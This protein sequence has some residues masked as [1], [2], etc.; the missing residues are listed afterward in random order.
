MDQ[1][2]EIVTTSKIKDNLHENLFY[3]IKRVNILSKLNY[4]FFFTSDHRSCGLMNPPFSASRIDIWVQKLTPEYFLNLAVSMPKDF[5]SLIKP[6]A[7]ISINFVLYRSY[8]TVFY[9]FLHCFT[10]FYIDRIKVD[11]LITSCGHSMCKTLHS[12]FTIIFAYYL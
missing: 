6:K 4:I 5:Q 3:I 9:D 10:I 11:G 1:V 12:L 8:I 2:S 7:I